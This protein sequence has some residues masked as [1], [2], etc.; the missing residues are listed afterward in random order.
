MKLNDPESKLNDP[1]TTLAGGTDADRF[2]LLSKHGL[3]QFT[4][5]EAVVNKTKERWPT[6]RLRRRGDEPVEYYLPETGQTV[7]VI[8]RG[9]PEDEGAP[10][11]NS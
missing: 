8:W 10:D 6:A 1:N 5:A 11:A 2:T 9:S 7:G 3:E 4:S